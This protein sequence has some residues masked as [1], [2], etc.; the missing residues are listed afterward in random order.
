MIELNIEQLNNARNE[1]LK[2][3]REYSLDRA[4]GAK[5][6]YQ[7]TDI[8]AIAA[9]KAQIQALLPKYE[10]F[11]QSEK[12]AQMLQAYFAGAEPVEKPITIYVAGGFGAGKTTLEEML[13]N[14]SGA[15]A[16]KSPEL[17]ELAQIL[18]GAK[19][20]SFADDILAHL[21]SAG[22]DKSD[23]AGTFWKIRPLM[24]GCHT[25]LNYLSEQIGVKRIDAAS[26][27]PAPGDMITLTNSITEV[28]R[29]SE[30]S[31]VV[32]IGNFVSDPKT[33]VERVIER[34]KVDGKSLAEQEVI[35]SHHGFAGAIAKYLPFVDHYILLNHDME[36]G[37]EPQ[38]VAKKVGREDT[39]IEIKDDKLYKQFFALG[40]RQAAQIGR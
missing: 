14:E 1:A 9:D 8:A 4:I 16:I 30:K 18:K 11:I 6:G 5:P 22:Y 31:R 15:E 13:L 25:A 28:Q 19:R 32:L 27:T 7:K 20:L 24:A 2:A 37:R 10:E 40:N 21:T 26:L 38:L 3:M 39:A 12:F 29:S 33:A 34:N 17:N 36:K 23:H 35:N